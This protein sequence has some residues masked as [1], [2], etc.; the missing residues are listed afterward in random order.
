MVDVTPLPLQIYIHIHALANEVPRY[1]SH[2]LIIAL[3]SGAPA[4]RMEG[5]Q[6]APHTHIGKKR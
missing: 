2:Y 3:Y 5:R 6:A 1:A 4:A